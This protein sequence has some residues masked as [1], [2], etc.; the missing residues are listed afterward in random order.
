MSKF[1]G[2]EIFTCEHLFGRP[3]KN[4]MILSLRCKII[5]HSNDII[6]G[7]VQSIIRKI[8]ATKY[9]LDIDKIKL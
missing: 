3:I 6:Q 1:F 5:N 7:Q 2:L 9:E 4:L 8:K